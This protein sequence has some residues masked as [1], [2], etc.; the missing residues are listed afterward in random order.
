MVV[1]S[2][3]TSAELQEQ[4]CDPS[5]S[6]LARRRSCRSLRGRQRWADGGRPA[7]FT[8]CIV[9]AATKQPQAADLQQ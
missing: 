8:A 3:R 6:H 5:R 1:E 7:R 2:Q 4:T 9:L